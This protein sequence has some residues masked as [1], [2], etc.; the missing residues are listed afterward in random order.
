MKKLLTLT[1][2]LASVGLSTTAFAFDRGLQIKFTGT[3]NANSFDV[4]PNVSTSTCRHKTDSVLCEQ[5]VYL[6]SK[7]RAT[8]TVLKNGQFIARINT[9]VVID[10][11]DMYM[12]KWKFKGATTKYGWNVEKTKATQGDLFLNVVGNK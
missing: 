8:Y 7:N 10:M 5:T 6:F 2:L 11:N 3:E 1:F 12:S 9:E 4:I